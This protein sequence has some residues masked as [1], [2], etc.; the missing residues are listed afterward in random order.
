M[1]EVLSY[2]SPK[3][4]SSII[5]ESLKLKANLHFLVSNHREEN[6]DNPRNLLKILTEL[7]K[8]AE[9]YNLQVI[10]SHTSTWSKQISLNLSHIVKRYNSISS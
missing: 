10:V 5:A 8:Q 4:Q 7:N 1:Y 9:S 6:V 2:Y 3:I